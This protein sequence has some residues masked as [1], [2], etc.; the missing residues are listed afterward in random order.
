MGLTAPGLC[1]NLAAF[2][3]YGNKWKMVADRLRIAV[4]YPQPSPT[5]YQLIKIVICTNPISP[6]APPEI[7]NPH[8][9]AVFYCDGMRVF[10]F[11][12]YRLILDRQKEVYL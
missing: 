9:F 2:W 1:Q 12:C 4:N 5:Q 6:S 8:L 7:D 3:G 11:S 10:L